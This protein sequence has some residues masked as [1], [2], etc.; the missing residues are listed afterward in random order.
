MD[1]TPAR[2]ALEQDD[3]EELRN[4]LDNGSDVHQEWNGFT[5]L[6]AAVDGEIDGHV[7]TGKPLHVDATALLLSKGADPTRPSHGGK[8]LSA[9]H[10]AFVSGHWLACDLFEAWLNRK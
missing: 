2:L 6:H 7:Q 10:L 9:H 8:G 3:L 1:M 5:L 4:L